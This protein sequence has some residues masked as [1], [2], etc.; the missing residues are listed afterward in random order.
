MINQIY[1]VVVRDDKIIHVVYV[2]SESSVEFVTKTA[3]D[4]VKILQKTIF[5]N[6]Q[7]N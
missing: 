1:K 7:F 3:V 5:I 2:P 6:P 4:V